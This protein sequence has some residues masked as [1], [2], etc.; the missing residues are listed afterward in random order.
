MDPARAPVIVGGALVVREVLRRYGL[1]GLDFSERDLLDGVALEA[2][3]R[4]RSGNNLR[5]QAFMYMLAQ[6]TIWR[7]PEMSITEQIDP[8]FSRPAPTA[9]TASTRR[10]RS[11]SSTWASAPSAAPSATSTPR[12]T[13]AGSPAPR[14]SRAS[15]SRTRTC[16]RTCCRPSSSTPS[17]T[18]RSPSR[19]SEAQVEGDRRH[20]SRARSRSRASRSPATLTGTI[21]GPKTD[22]YGNE[23][24][25]L[26]LETTVDRTAFGIT[27]NADMPNGTKALSDEVTLKADLSLVK[28]A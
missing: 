16:T 15:R 3:A 27:W 10:S 17:A 23:R 12:S 21:V 28:A 11:R 26:K 25:G 9:S 14:G 7:S 22:P 4:C 24:Y 13:T 1:P 2:G 6:S 18:P 8:R 20:A 5:A 19:P